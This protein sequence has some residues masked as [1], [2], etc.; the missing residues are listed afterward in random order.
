L[1]AAVAGLV[2]TPPQQRL[3][4]VVVVAVDM[5]RRGMKPKTLARRLRYMLVRGALLAPL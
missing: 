2:V 5:M 3:A 4:A 1:T